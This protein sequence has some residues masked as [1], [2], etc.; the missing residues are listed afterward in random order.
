MIHYVC[1]KV[2]ILDLLMT[3][4]PRVLEENQRVFLYGPSKRQLKQRKPDI[5]S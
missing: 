1:N 5:R 2:E 3:Q 4:Y